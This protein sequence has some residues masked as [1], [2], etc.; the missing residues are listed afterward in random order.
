MVRSPT[1]PANDPDPLPAWEGPV[2]PRDPEEVALSQN[3]WGPR[4]SR[5]APDLQ[6]STGP[7]PGLGSPYYPTPRLG[8]SGAATCPQVR[9]RARSRV[10][11]TGSHAYL[12]HSKRQAEVRTAIAEPEA[13]FA[14][15]HYWS[16]VTK[17]HNAVAGEAHAAYVS[18]LCQLSMM[19][20]L[21]LL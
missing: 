7:P 12:P 10:A 6:G 15:L 3:S 19:A 2:A 8:W 13:A 11:S 14:R 4:T 16:R 1:L 5:G 18:L 9:A 21:R 20:R 17:A